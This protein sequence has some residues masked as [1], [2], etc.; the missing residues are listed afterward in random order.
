VH[1]LAQLKWKKYFYYLLIP[2]WYHT[3]IRHIFFAP[4]DL[5]PK[6][7]NQ[8]NQM[9]HKEASVPQ[10]LGADRW[11]HLHKPDTVAHWSAT[12]RSS[13]PCQDPSPSTSHSPINEE[14]ERESGTPHRD[15]CY[16]APPRVFVDGKV[17]VSSIAG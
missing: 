15:F 16:F 2:M 12:C 14:R 17:S 6:I 5:N 8:A 11:D 3:L 7:H 13:R 1:I 10:I 4:L 9:I